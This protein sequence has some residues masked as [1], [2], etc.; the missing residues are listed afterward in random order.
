M[1]WSRRPSQV[2]LNG[3]R[4]VDET[5]HLHGMTPYIDQQ[6]KEISWASAGR[7]QLGGHRGE[8]PQ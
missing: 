4:W 8:V 1:A 2:N 5:L 6:P 3:Q 7:D